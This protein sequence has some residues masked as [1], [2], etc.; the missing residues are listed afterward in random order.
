MSLYLMIISPMPLYTPVSC[1]PP[2]KAARIHL[3]LCLY[4]SHFS[5]LFLVYFIYMKSIYLFLFI[6]FGLYR[7]QIS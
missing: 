5:V 2:K 3:E 7:L 4:F 1:L 6:F